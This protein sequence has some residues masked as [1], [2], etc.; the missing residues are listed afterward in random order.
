MACGCG[1]NNIILNQYK[2][3]NWVLF[4]AH[5]IAELRKEDVQIYIKEENKD[6]TIYGIEFPLNKNRNQIVRIIK[7]QELE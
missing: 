5:Q 7:W 1:K 4:R 6:Y 3:W 2:N